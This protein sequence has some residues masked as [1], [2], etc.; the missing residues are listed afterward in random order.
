[1]YERDASTYPT[2]PVTP[3]GDR[4][5]AT[6]NVA[7]IRGTDGELVLMTLTE[8]EETVRTIHELREEFPHPQFR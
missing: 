8:L 6:R 3:W 4:I 1:M 2:A 7:Y 5:K